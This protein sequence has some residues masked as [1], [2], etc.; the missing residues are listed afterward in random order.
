MKK[1]IIV[2][3]FFLFGCK[4]PLG[5]GES[6]LQDNPQDKNSVII[7]A[8]DSLTGEVTF[9]NYTDYRNARELFQKKKGDKKLNSDELLEEL[10]K[11]K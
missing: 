1:F 2:F 3:A 11:I 9:K 7:Y 8:I 5:A 6:I 4:N 10:K